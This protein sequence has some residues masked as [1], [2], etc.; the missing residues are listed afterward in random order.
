MPSQAKRVAILHFHLAAREAIEALQQVERFL[1]SH[2]LHLG[3]VLPHQR[4]RATVVGLHVM[5]HDIVDR[6][7]A[8]HLANILDELR[9][10]VG[11]HRIN[12]THLLVYNEI[13]V[14]RHTVRQR[15]QSFELL[16]LSVVHT[17]IISVFYYFYHLSVFY[18]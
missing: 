6:T 10:K 13:R 9:K 1:I 2:H 14:V 11:L 16:F 15:P 18:V 8:Y 7:V 12:Q 17:H 4:K 3:I 5:G